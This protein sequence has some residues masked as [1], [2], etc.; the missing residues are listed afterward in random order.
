MRSMRFI[1]QR[2]TTFNL[3]NII[4]RRKTESIQ[5]EESEKNQSNYAL[6]ISENSFGL[7]A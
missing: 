6:I 5:F 4:L 2:N 1:R 7:H 3:S